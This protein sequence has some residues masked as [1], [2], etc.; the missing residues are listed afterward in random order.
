MSL[1]NRE[2]RHLDRISS[3]LQASD[4]GLATLLA[5]FE[6]L[7]AGEPMPRW[8]QRRQ[9]LLFRI[10]STLLWTVFVIISLITRAARTCG[11]RLRPQ[12]RY[13]RQVL[14]ARPRGSGTPGHGGQ[15]PD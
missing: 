12:R 15:V 1:C 5:Q 11:S 6:S 13:M 2:R 10:G 4:P 14:D 7:T 9:R 8:E 3:A